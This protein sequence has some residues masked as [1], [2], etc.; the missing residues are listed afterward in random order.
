MPIPRRI[1]LLIAAALVIIISSA[2][3]S[4]AD[5]G[6]ATFLPPLTPGPLLRQLLIMARMLWGSGTLRKLAC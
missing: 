4:R 2:D 1:L 5:F 6:R 3:D